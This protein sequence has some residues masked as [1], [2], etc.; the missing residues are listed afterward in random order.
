M[1]L[2]LGAGSSSGCTVVLNRFRSSIVFLSALAAIFL[3]KSPDPEQGESSSTPA[4]PDTSPAF[5]LCSVSY[6]GLG[7]Q[8]VD[9][10]FGLYLLQSGL[11]LRFS[12]IRVSAYWLMWHEARKRQSPTVPSSGAWRVCSCGLQ[13][14][15]DATQRFGRTH[16][17]VCNVLS[18][19]VCCGIS[20]T[21]DSRSCNKD[22]HV[23]HGNFTRVTYSSTKAVIPQTLNI[24]FVLRQYKAGNLTTHLQPM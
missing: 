2:T 6:F 24:G 11:G 19:V 5:F 13:I 1:S 18:Y 7:G 16:P 15:I 23:L 8:R 3:A 10:T 22:V 12:P 20:T 4:H 14:I 21:C 17:S 9:A